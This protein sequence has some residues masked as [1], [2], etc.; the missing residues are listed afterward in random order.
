MSMSERRDTFEPV[1]FLSKAGN[2]RTNEKHQAGE[3]IYSQG[4]LGSAGLLS[5][6]GQSHEDRDVAKRQ[7]R[8]SGDPGA[9]RFF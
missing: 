3:T 1:N 4:D 5:A 6:K 2:G 8:G 9:G 7:R